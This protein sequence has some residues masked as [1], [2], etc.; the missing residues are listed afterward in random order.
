MFF[1]VITLN[2]TKKNENSGLS[3]LKTAC[4][5]N[6]TNY[7]RPQTI[8]FAK[9]ENTYISNCQYRL[10]TIYYNCGVLLQMNDKLIKTN[11]K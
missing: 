7:L 1:L 4:F 11:K 5:F 6:E 2:I 10:A 9:V 8:Y 3:T